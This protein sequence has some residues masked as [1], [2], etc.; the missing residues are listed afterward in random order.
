MTLPIR[1]LRSPRSTLFSGFV[2]GIFATGLVLALVVPSMM[3]LIL[4]GQKFDSSLYEPEIQAVLHEIGGEFSV[5]WSEREFIHWANPEAVKRI[6]EDM[7][8]RRPSV[9]PS[10][11]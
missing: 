5:W 11:P 8:S 2:A 10:E 1:L 6:L 3:Q 9:S 7:A 4:P